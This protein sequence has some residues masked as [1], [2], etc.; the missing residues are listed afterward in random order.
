[1][2]TRRQLIVGGCV[3]A[4]S[5][6]LPNV[7]HAQGESLRIVVGFPAG[8]GADAIARKLAEKLRS[9]MAMGVIV[10]N[11]AGASGR[12]AATQ[13]KNAA[14][15]GRTLLITP[16]TSITILP[17][18]YKNLPYDPI[19]DLAPIS[20]VSTVPLGFVVGP[21]AKGVK[22]LTEYAQWVKADPKNTTYASPGPGSGAH[23]LGDMFAKAAGLDL[24]HVPYRGAAPAQ[25]DLIAGQIPAYSGIVGR[26][27]LTE[28]RTGRLKVLAISQ[29]KRSAHLPDVPT[30]AEAGFPKVAASEWTGV[31]APGR[32]PISVIENLN[33]HVVAAMRS[34]DVTQLLDEGGQELIAN[35]ASAFAVQI[36]AETALWGPAIRASGFKP[37]D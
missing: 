4:T 14:P 7:A 25:Q 22:T 6:C 30:F 26:I 36:A 27:V 31:F 35:S 12:M 1:M 9:S 15:D 23:F 8:A 33:K 17:H 13:V 2:P 24:V 28:H 21:G 16:A 5:I 10:E 37:E 34:T 11:V 19:R 18:L 3:S 20:A 29:S 32:T